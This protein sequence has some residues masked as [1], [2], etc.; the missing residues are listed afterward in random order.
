MITV[1]DAAENPVANATVV[2]KWSNGA[3][4]TASC[5]TDAGGVCQ[6]TKTGLRGNTA[7][8]RFSVTKVTLS[9]F[10]Y[11]AAANHDPDGDSTGTVIVVSK[12]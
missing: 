10:T 11:T 2:G 7:S 8:V 12:P 9:S 3:S 5:V 4:G 1:H 6:V